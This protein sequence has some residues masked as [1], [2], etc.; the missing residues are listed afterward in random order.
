[1]CDR[2]TEPWRSATPIV[3][4]GIEPCVY[5]TG[6]SQNHTGKTSLAVTFTKLEIKVPAAPEKQEHAGLYRRGWYRDKRTDP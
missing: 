3:V 5:A 1:M 4:K 2:A 6:K